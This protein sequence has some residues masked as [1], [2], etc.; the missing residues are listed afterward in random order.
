[1]DQLSVVLKKKNQRGVPVSSLGAAVCLVHSSL[2][3]CNLILIC[4]N[5]GQH[6]SDT[7]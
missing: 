5:N 6:W 3:E 7:I 4:D 1:M 2:R